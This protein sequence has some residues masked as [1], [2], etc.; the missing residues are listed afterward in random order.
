MLLSPLGYK[1]PMRYPKPDN[2]SP[3]TNFSGDWPVKRKQGAARCQSWNPNQGRQCNSSPVKGSIRCDSHG[4]KSL[5]GIAS[6]T[7]KTGIY[8]KHLPAKLSGN[9][10]NLLT[11]G[12]DLFKIDDETAA[13]T[14]LIQ[15]QLER[16]E[17]GESGATWGK[18]QDL[19]DEME[20]LGQKQDKSSE[21]IQRFNT[22]FVELGKIVNSGSMV[23]AARNE[24]VGLMEQK[25]KLVSDERKNWAAKHQAMSF[26][27]VMLILTAMAA[28]FKQSLEKHIDDAKSQRAVLSD[29]Q[30]FL[31]RVISE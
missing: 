27:R 11:L 28:C 8:S 22:L 15:Q 5:S 6:P 7:Y 18:L 4:G 14:T 19:Y 23:F 21:D 31:S 1:T 30:E 9:Y 29:A 13:M 24:A 12:Q 16:M 25:R 26:D 17:S 10:Q 20:I 2:F 3:E